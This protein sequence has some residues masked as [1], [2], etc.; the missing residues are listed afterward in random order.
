M[1]G[2]PNTDWDKSIKALKENG[3][4]AIVPCMAWSSCANYKSEMLAPSP[5]FKERGDQLDACLA[6]CRKYG[7]ELHVWKMCWH[8]G[9]K[10]ADSEFAARMRKRGLMQVTSGGQVCADALCPS[11]PE[12]LKH[13]V[14]SFVEIAKKGVDG[15][16]LDHIRTESTT[17]FC[18]GC[19]NRF[20]KLIGRKFKKWP[21]D[22]QKD[23]A[24]MRR[25]YDFRA[26]C[27]SELVRQVSEAVRKAAPGVKISAAVFSNPAS[28]KVSLGQDWP[29]WCRMGWVDM[30][31]PMNYTVS[32]LLLKSMVEAQKAAA[33]D[34]VKVFPGLGISLWPKG[35]DTIRVAGE[36]IETIRNAGLEGMIFFNYAAWHLPQL[37]AL[38]QGPFAEAPEKKTCSPAVGYML[39]V[40]RNKVPT[41]PTMRRIVDIISRMGYNQL[42]LY[43][44]HAFAY[45]G[46]ETAWQGVSPFTP[47]EVRE[48]DGYCRDRGIELVPNQNS[49]GH[50][51]NWFEHMEYRHLAELPEGGVRIAWGG[52]THEPRAL[53]PTS[54]KTF[55]FLDDLYSQLLPCKIKASFHILATKDPSTRTA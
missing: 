6:A 8:L 38:R 36:Q 24:M 50:L 3:F 4:T 44:E 5:A 51:E 47:A 10:R 17:C 18:E 52:R 16:H 25:W 2:D 29:R 39:D 21:E 54:P 45:K 53:C 37:E 34:K 12:V 15:V 14:V 19:R 27:V 48:L 30:V 49:F 9:G 41:M 23:D 46:Y 32:P 22:M 13:E 40:S 55:A 28:D 35:T 11:D 26:G 7:I 20:E 31:C 1:G 42:Q 43:F 33:G